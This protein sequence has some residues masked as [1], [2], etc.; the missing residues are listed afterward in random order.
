MPA[1]ACNDG[2]AS[3]PHMTARATVVTPPSSAAH[4]HVPRSGLTL[5]FTKRRP[6]GVENAGIRKQDHDAHQR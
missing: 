1:N 6:E 4:I 5:A 3:Q 2:G